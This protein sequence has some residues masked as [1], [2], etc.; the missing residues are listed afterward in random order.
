L[1]DFVL[2]KALGSGAFG[3]VFPARHKRTNWLVAIKKIRKEKVK[4]MLDQ[5]IK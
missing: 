2:G 4:H 5:L 1:K 3:E